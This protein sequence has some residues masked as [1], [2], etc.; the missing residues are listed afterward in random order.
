MISKDQEPAQ[1]GA[2]KLTLPERGEFRLGAG[3][4]YF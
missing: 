2:K 4:G 3:N 1:W